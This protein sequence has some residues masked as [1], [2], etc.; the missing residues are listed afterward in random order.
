MKAVT[1]RDAALCLWFVLVGLA[2]WG[3]V[4]GVPVPDF[5]AAY[6]LFLVAAIAALALRLLRRETGGGG[7][8]P[9]PPAPALNPR[10]GGS[11]GRGR[12]RPRK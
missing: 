1:A 12:A 6:G 7:D 4:A 3:P 8:E 2:F 11:G 5:T 9:A 10:R